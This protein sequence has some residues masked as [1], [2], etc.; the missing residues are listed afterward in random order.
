M[1]ERTTV[2][3]CK[4][5]STDTY[6]GRGQNQRDLFETPIGERGWL[7]NP[8]TLDDYERDESVAKFKEVFLDRIES[9]QAFQ[10]AVEEL[11]GNTLGCWCQSLEDDEPACHGEIIAAYL[12]GEL[13]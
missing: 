3:H 4:R 10:N 1:T 11:R 6:I 13:E 7:G 2:G 12:N 5:N 8:F 9:D